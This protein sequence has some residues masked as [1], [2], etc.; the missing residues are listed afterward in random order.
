MGADKGDLRW[1]VEQR[2]EFVEFRLFLGA[3]PRH[4]QPGISS[5]I[6]NRYPIWTG[7]LFCRKPVCGPAKQMRPSIGLLAPPKS[8]RLIIDATQREQ[9]H[10]SA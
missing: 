10:G 4:T 5:L 8:M 3:P 2:L 1:G 7:L 6:S 9:R